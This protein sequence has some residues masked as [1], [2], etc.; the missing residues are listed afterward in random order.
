MPSLKITPIP[1]RSSNLAIPPSPFSPRSPLTLAPRSK[2]PRYATR[3]GSILTK[4]P[5]VAPLQWVWQCHQCR[6]TYPLGATRRCLEDGHQ[7]CS[8][9]SVVKSRRHGNR[10]VVKKHRACASEFDYAAWKTLGEWR[11]DCLTPTTP[12]FT[13][14][15]DCW[16][17]CNYPSECRWGSKLAQPQ[18]SPTIP[19]SPPQTSSKGKKSRQMKEP[20]PATTYNQLLQVINHPATTLQTLLSPNSKRKTLTADKWP[21]SQLN[22]VFEEADEDGDIAMTDAALVS[23][24]SSAIKFAAEQV[25]QLSVDLC[26]R[27]PKASVRKPCS[28]FSAFDFGFEESG[29]E[30][31][32]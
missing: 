6:Q 12:S 7:F 32:G 31:K 11:R 23:P 26:V 4:P 10:K 3:R 24:P 19:E 1:Y 14:K 5:Q 22:I 8:G 21:L 29:V 17:N 9:T 2:K 30:S 16:H 18:V 15:K 28:P 27:P 25:A 20:G 13:H